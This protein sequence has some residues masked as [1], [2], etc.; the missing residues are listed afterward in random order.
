MKDVSSVSILAS[1]NMFSTGS[2][3]L[4]PLA[5]TKGSPLLVKSLVETEENCQ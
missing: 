2:L 5:K 4:Q 3:L 1:Y